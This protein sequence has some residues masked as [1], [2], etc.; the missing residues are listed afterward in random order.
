MLLT[1][2][3]SFLREKQIAPRKSLSQNFLVDRNVADKIVRTADIQPGDLVLE[4]GSGPGMLTRALLDQGARIIAVEK[5]RVWAAELPRLQTAD[6]RLTVHCEDILEFPLPT[7][8]FKVVANLPYHITTPILVKLCEHLPQMVSAT[9]MMQMEVAQRLVELQQSSLS[10]FIQ[11]F[12]TAALKFRVTPTCFFPQP[13]V[14]SAIVRI[15]SHLPPTVPQEPFF[16]LVRTAFQ[17]KRKMLSGSLQKLYSAAVVQQALTNIGVRIDA[18]P[19]ML[20]LDQ[21]IELFYSIKSEVEGRNAEVK[22]GDPESF[23]P[24][25]ELPLPTSS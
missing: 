20:S 25:S 17:H 11:F 2:L 12:G 21:W 5:D 3:C 8:P 13:S 14:D 18:R 1:E 6:G 16:K 15:D 9:V 19:H 24:T 7:E 23:L 22:N 4:I 10:I